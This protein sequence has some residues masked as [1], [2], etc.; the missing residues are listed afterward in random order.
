MRRIL[1]SVV[2]L[3]L[4]TMPSIVSSDVFEVSGRIVSEEGGSLG[5][6][7]LTVDG[8]SVAVDAGGNF[9]F[10]IN[11]RWSAVHRIDVVLEGY[12]PALQTVHRSDF[13]AGRAAQLPAI[14]LVRKKPQRRLLMF[15]GD[16]MLSRR[17]MEPRAGEPALAR[18]NTM[19]ADAKALLRHIKPYIELADLASVNME[20]QLSADP[21]V[22]PLA[23]SVTFYSPPELAEALK[24]AGVD[25]VALG[26]NHMFDFQRPGLVSTLKILDELELAYS[27]GDH[28]DALARRPAFVAVGDVPY[29]FLSY[30]GWAGTF[31]PSQVAEIDKGGAA[32]GDATSIARDLENIPKGTTSVVQLHS[33]IEYAAEPSLSEQTMLHNAVRAGGD[34]VIGHHPHVLQGLDIVDNR[35]IAYSLG[36]FLFDQY[37]YT[38]QM[39]MLLFVWMDGEQLHRAEVVPLHLNGYVPT[40]AT[41]EF[42]YAILHRLAKLSNR[43]NVCIRPSG[44]HLVAERCPDEASPGGPSGAGVQL[45]DIQASQMQRSSAAEHPISLRAAGASPLYPVVIDDAATAYRLGVD[46]LRRGEFEH[47]DL[48]DTVDRTWIENDQVYAVTGA[49]THLAVSIGAGTNIARSGLRVFDR[50][51]TLSNP[52]TFAGRVK[53]KG[54]ARLRVFLQRRPSTGTFSDALLTGPVTEIGSVRL[55]KDGW[56]TFSFDYNQPRLATKSLRIL[57]SVEDLTGEGVEAQFDDLAWVEWRTPWLEPDAEALGE[58]ATHIQFQL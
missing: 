47:V 21:L 54:E 16:A 31:K 8:E 17:Y 19:A 32:L 2:V 7:R 12:Y 43:R 44:L 39:S 23:K 46:L 14:E 20:T 6:A 10:P 45:I 48:F 25:Y 3:L 5:S 1:Q 28:N 4:T 38:T 56:H 49:S 15:A 51:F 53:L 50:V 11:R 52:A 33:G 26:N 34:I 24:W 18:A 9:S 13:V 37:I 27:G 35:L 58:Y 57:F 41:G 36:N 55:E 29:G 40:P 42:R 30:V 22:T